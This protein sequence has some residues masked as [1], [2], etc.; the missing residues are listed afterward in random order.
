MKSSWVC[1]ISPNA[2]L[3][4]LLT[5]FFDAGIVFR[6]A[7]R[8]GILLLLAL[9]LPSNVWQAADA[10]ATVTLA[11]DNGTW[12]T[13]G[14]DPLI[15]P[16][17]K[18]SLPSG[19]SSA[20]LAS[21]RWVRFNDALPLTI[22]VTGPDHVTELSG[23]PITLTA[24]GSDPAATGCPAGWPQCSGLDLT[25]YGFVVTGDFFVIFSLGNLDKD[26]GPGSGRSY[27]GSSFAVLTVTSIRRTCLFEFT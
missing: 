19:V 26:T 17:V 22:H 13:L 15:L 21:V 14:G 11:Y 20:R 5:T 9:V 25:S 8:L 12:D 1:V 27:D 10:Q 3:L 2:K 4:F 24:P 6:L 23:S 16:G 7:Y 18:F